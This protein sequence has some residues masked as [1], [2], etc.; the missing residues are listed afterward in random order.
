MYKLN[1]SLKRKSQ[2]RAIETQ[3]AIIDAALQEFAAYGFEGAS[4]RR[5]AEAASVNPALITHHFGGKDGL[6]RAVAEEV[7]ERYEE[8]IQVRQAGL[9]GVDEPTQL[10]LLLREFILFAARTPELHRFMIQANQGDPE[11]LDWLVDRF[12]RTGNTGAVFERA[13][14][15]GLFPAGDPMHLRYLFIG[16]AT[17][18]FI[19]SGELE[20]LGDVDPFDENTIEKHI[21]L[22]LALFL[23]EEAND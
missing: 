5:I 19:F 21:D 10:R 16:A 9:E 13:Q 8:R 4:A 12:V 14:V 7:F 11:R 20:R 1:A 23:K 3:T 15:L 17:S 22:V 2:Q 18:I 6:W